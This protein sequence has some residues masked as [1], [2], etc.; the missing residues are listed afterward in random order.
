MYGSSA[1]PQRPFDGYDFWQI[2]SYAG[3]VLSVVAYFANPKLRSELGKVATGFGV[4]SAAHAVL[5][6]PRCSWCSSRM[7]KPATNYAGGPQWVCGC[8]NALYPTT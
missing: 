5:T 8:G 4:A 7:S 6:P 2:V 1:Q 3:T